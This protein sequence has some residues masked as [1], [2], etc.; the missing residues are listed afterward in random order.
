MH[1]TWIIKPEVFH[2]AEIN[3]SSGNRDVATV[4]KD[5]RITGVNEGEVIITASV[6][7]IA[8]IQYKTGKEWSFYADKIYGW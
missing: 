4:S 8:E 1:L 3:W 2:G 6:D 7:G 5:G